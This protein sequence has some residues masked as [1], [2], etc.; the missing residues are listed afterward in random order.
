MEFPPITIL[1]AGSWGTALAVHL[2][3]VGQPVNLWEFDKDQVALLQRDRTNQRYLPGIAL[4]D[5]V[6]VFADMTDA[7]VGAQDVLL[8]VPSFAFAQTL[9][10]LKPLIN[11]DTRVAWGTKGIDHDSNRLLHELVLEN[12]GERPIAVLSGPSFAKEVA[13]GL[14]TAIVTASNDKTFMQDLVAR[15]NQR[16][17]RVYM[18][19]DIIGVQLGGSV[20]NVIA[21]AVG[22]S[23]GLHYGANAKSALI[24]RGLAEIMRL[25]VAMGARPQTFMGLSGMGD[26]VLTCTDDQSRNRRLGLAIAKGK[27]IES[28]MEEIGQVVEGIN[29]VEQVLYLANKYQV[30]MPICQQVYRV[31]HGKVQLKDAVTEL[32]SRGPKFE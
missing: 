21:I 32:L 17:F 30:E 18:S 29:T 24:T 13:Q 20:K 31:L 19:E 28:A 1:G 9:L 2:A 25:G 26:L 14:P 11:S 15:F 6:Q 4:P 27:S 3:R 5:S 10:S 23:D 22:A 16:A 8:V 12:L 7:V